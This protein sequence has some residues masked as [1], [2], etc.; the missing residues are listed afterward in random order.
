[1]EYCDWCQGG[2]LDLVYN[3]EDDSV[4]GDIDDK[5]GEMNFYIGKKIIGNRVVNYCPMCGRPVGRA[6]E[7]E[8]ADWKFL[9][10]ISS[11]LDWRAPSLNRLSSLVGCIAWDDAKDSVGLRFC[12]DATLYKRLKDKFG[13]RFP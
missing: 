5:T 12:D 7:E 3:I 4:H 1:M 6:L 13:R 2:A 9:E 11:V 10:K 8:D